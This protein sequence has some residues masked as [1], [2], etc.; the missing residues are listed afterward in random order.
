M[1]FIK[2]IH[3]TSQNL[4]KALL[5]SISELYSSDITVIRNESKIALIDIEQLIN[6]AIIHETPEYKPM[7]IKL[8][9]D[10]LLTT[11]QLFFMCLHNKLSL[12]IIDKD[13]N[14]Y[15]FINGN[16]TTI[17]HKDSIMTFEYDSNN[18]LIK[19]TKQDKIK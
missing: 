13:D 15:T 9:K 6:S 4:P 16:W 17:E 12:T 5:N 19:R 8:N 18:K 1:S 10:A 2:N 14:K 7:I 11:G 3:M